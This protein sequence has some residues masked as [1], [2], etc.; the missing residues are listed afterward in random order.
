M[1]QVSSYLQRKELRT[2]FDK[3]LLKDKYKWGGGEI[4]F[5]NGQIFDFQWPVTLTLDR[6]ILHQS[7]TST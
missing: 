3:Q 7:S 1:L 6:V 4:A 5:E 2:S